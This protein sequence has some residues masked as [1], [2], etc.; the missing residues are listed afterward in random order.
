MK[1]TR[2]ALNSVVALVLISGL[3]FGWRVTHK[4]PAKVAPT[5][6]TAFIGNISNTVS[7]Q[8]SIVSNSDSNL[9]FGSSGKVTSL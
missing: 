4:T 6:A 5:Y 9:T 2:I 3:I 1:R 8:G 7:A